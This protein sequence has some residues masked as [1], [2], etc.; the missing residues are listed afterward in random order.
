MLLAANPQ[1]Q[2]T[3]VINDKW[4]TTDASHASTRFAECSRG[5]T[6]AK[7]LYY[8]PGLNLVTWR[9][10]SK[11]ASVAVHFLIHYFNAIAIEC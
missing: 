8:W 4:V 5:L 7:T 3:L 9:R 2:L 10:R 11:G 6:C 1:R